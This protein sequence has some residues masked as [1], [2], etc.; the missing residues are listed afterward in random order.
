MLR[1]R[2]AIDLGTANTL[3]WVAGSACSY[4]SPFHFYPNT[5]QGVNFGGLLLHI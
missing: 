3:V 1:K 2:L 4:L 5:A